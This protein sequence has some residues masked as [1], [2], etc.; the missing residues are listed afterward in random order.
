V[1]TVAEHD[2]RHGDF[3]RLAH[4]PA[5]QRVG[6]L[7]SR[8]HRQIVRL[9]EVARIDLSLVDEIDDIDGP[10]DLQCDLL[11]V[12]VIE[13]HVM[14]WLVLVALDQVLIVDWLLVRLADTQRF[15]R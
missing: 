5:Q 11:E 10:G 3:P 15:D 7:A 6:L 1:L 4:R 13:D 14:P 8:L 12:L 2:L 9:V